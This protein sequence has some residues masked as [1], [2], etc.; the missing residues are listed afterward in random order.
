[1]KATGG[2]GIS[3]AVNFAWEISRFKWAVKFPTRNSVAKLH[4][5][6]KALHV[7]REPGPNP[8]HRGQGLE[9]EHSWPNGAGI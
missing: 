4:R 1:M 8:S 5:A 7:E 9:H 2:G 6:C 3:G